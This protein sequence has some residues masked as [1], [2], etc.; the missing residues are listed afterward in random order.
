MTTADLQADVI[1]QLRFAEGLVE[2][3][4]A[5][6]L[7]LAELTG[8]GAALEGQVQATV[9]NAGRPTALAIAPRAMRTGSEAL[10]EAVLAAF[11]EAHDALSAQSQHLLSALR[12][13]LPEQLRDPIGS[14]VVHDLAEHGREVTRTLQTS[15][16]PGGDALHLARDLSARVLGG[17]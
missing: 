6:Q 4:R 2:R 11:A 3:G 12:D 17:I 8:T 1:R 16:D 7:E 10:A 9:D 5:L 14:G 13:D 15:T